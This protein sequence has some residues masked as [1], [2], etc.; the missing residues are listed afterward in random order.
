VNVDKPTRPSVVDIMSED[1]TS[2][3]GIMGIAVSPDN[4]NVY[5]CNRPRFRQLCRVAV[6]ELHCALSECG[7][8]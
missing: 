6:A 8:R 4:N 5:V 7:T 2:M 3:A 1:S